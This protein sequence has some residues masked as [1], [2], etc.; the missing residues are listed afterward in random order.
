MSSIVF[1]GAP[2]VGKGTQREMFVKKYPY[3]ASIVPGDIMRGEVKKNLR[4]ELHWRNISTKD[5]LH[6]TIW[7]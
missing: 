7:Q 4:S 2:G 5:C 6:L 3:F 1:I